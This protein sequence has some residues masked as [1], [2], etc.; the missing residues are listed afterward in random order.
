M[1]QEN[2][3]DSYIPAAVPRSALS[4]GN[5]TR[6]F[7]LLDLMDHKFRIN[8]SGVSNPR[9]GLGVAAFTKGGAGVEVVVSERK[10]DLSLSVGLKILGFR[11]YCI[12]YASIERSKY[13]NSRQMSSHLCSGYDGSDN[14]VVR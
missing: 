13:R 3:T 9:A 14:S 5:P 12:K 7:S 6:V 8:A 10:Y 2:T 11:S 4:T 1:L